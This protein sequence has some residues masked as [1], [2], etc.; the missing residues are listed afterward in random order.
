[1][2]GACL[3]LWEVRIATMVDLKKNGQ[4]CFTDAFGSLETSFKTDF[5][6]IFPNPAIFWL[7]L[8]AL[9]APRLGST[10]HGLNKH[11]AANVIFYYI[12]VMR[13]M[14]IF[15]KMKILIFLRLK[16]RII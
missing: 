5:L 8:N 16:K 11:Y 15:L 12:L 6:Y 3:I 14:S 2:A 13:K 1:M 10:Q 7:R 9:A 4:V